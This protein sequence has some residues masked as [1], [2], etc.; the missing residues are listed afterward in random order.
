[1]VRQARISREQFNHP[2][3]LMPLISHLHELPRNPL[4]QKLETLTPIAI[5]RASRDFLLQVA[6]DERKKRADASVDARLAGLSAALTPGNGADE[7]LGGVYNG[8]AAVAL[9]RVLA[10]GRDTG[11]PHVVGDLRDAVLVP[12]GGASNDGNVNFAESSGAG[13]ALGGGSPGVLLA[14]FQSR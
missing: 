6:V 3:P 12:A 7:G 14:W 13:S 1:M 4:H 8:A 5:I 9:A 2:S 11:A 10:S